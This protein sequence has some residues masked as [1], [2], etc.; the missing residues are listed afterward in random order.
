MEE[1]TQDDVMA[2]YKVLEYLRDEFDFPRDE[3]TFLNEAHCLVQE[4]EEFGNIPTSDEDEIQPNYG[5][6]GEN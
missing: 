2:T 6:V 4:C 3:R 5:T 1:I